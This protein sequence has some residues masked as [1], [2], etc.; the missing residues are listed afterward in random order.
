MV[1]PKMPRVKSEGEELAARGKL[2]ELEVVLADNLS[3][4]TSTEISSRC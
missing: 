1:S 3:S 2:N 4:D